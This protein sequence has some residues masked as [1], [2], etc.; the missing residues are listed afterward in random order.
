MPGESHVATLDL[1]FEAGPDYAISG[2]ANFLFIKT[3]TTLYHLP[4]RRS[5]LLKLGSI[6]I[7][8]S[9]RSSVHA[10]PVSAEESLCPLVV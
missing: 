4:F 2:R 3:A 7:M 10:A 8:D 1:I 5:N 9:V 6:A